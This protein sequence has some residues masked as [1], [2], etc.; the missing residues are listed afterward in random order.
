MDEVDRDQEFNEQQLEM[1]I[2][3]SRPGEQLL[4]SLKHCNVPVNSY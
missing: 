1:M 3:L 4:L 2:A